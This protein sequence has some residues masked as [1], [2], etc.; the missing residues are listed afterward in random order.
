MNDDSIFISI[1]VVE[2]EP[3]KLTRARLMNFHRKR[4]TNSPR[5]IQADRDSYSNSMVLLLMIS[6]TNTRLPTF[7]TPRQQIQFLAASPLAFPSTLPQK[8]GPNDLFV[9]P[10]PRCVRSLSCTYSS[11]FHLVPT[12]TPAAAP[13]ESL[14]TDIPIESYRC[15]GVSS[16]NPFHH[17]QG[18]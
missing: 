12:I 16:T 14:D 17:L 1:H 9:L 7:A 4:A 13:R 8:V 3:R 18:F 6:T 5:R 15:E 2:K 10:Q 11:H